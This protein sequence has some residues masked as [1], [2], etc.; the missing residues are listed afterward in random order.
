MIKTLTA[1]VLAATLT[2]TGMAPTTAAADISREQAIVGIGALLLLGA[3]IH[4][5]RDDDDDNDRARS[6]SRRTVDV[7]RN[8][9][10]NDRW[11]VLPANCLIDTRSRRGDRVRY[12]GQHCLTNNYANVGRLPH[13]CHIRFRTQSRQVRQGFDARCLR[14]AGFRTTRR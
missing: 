6:S 12:F 1:G 4:N 9:H 8:R 10:H 13:N 5:D 7:T 3:A 14:E 2:V 11:R